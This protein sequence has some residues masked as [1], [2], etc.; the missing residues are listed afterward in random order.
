LAMRSLLLTILVLAV[1]KQVRR[2]DGDVVLRCS[3]D[4]SNL[5]HRNLYQSLLNQNRDN[6]DFWSRNDIHLTPKSLPSVSSALQAHK[7]PCTTLIEDVQ[8]LVDAERAYSRLIKERE[9]ANTKINSEDPN[10]DPF[11]D[12]YRTLDQIHTWCRNLQAKFPDLVEVEQLN[13]TYEGRQI[14]VVK[15]TNGPK[16]KKP[17][18]FYEGGIHAREWI[19]PATVTY[20]LGKLTNTSDPNATQLLNVYEFHIVPV[21]NGDGYNYTWTTDRSWR[22]TRSPNA[23]SPCIGTDPNRNWDDHW[24]VVGASTNPC[25]DS[26]CG[27]AAFTEREVVTMGNHV[28]RTPNVKMFIDWHAYG[29]LWMA[30][31]G[32]SGA[33]PPD[34]AAQATTGN[35]AVTA[36]K[37]VNNLTYTY[38]TIYNIIYPAS[39][40]SADY[41]YDVGKVVYSYGVEL[42]DTGTYGFLLPANQ[43]RPQGEEIWAAVIA[44]LKVLP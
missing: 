7:V 11:F 42:R 22:K 18:I 4:F 27:S 20:L 40:S 35:I 39:G 19:T 30:P 10:P 32:W 23:R 2:F 37:G 6:V 13:T 41:G 8:A 34:G 16:G 26:Y 38:G 29:Q 17:V 15:V 28:V 25:S 14:L 9:Q 43:I 3:F 5:E 36:I 33:T 21:V 31:W 12:D 24:C 1:A 44:M